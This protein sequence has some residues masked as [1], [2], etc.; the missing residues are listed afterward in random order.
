MMIMWNMTTT[1]WR[2][3]FFPLAGI[4]VVSLSDPCA[5]S[6]GFTWSKR[7][8][9]T[10]VEALKPSWA[11]KPVQDSRS[12]L[13]LLKS[14]FN[15][16]F[17]AEDS[18]PTCP[19]ELGKGSLAFIRVLATNHFLCL[20]IW[21]WGGEVPKSTCVKEAWIFSLHS[22]KGRFLPGGSLW[23]THLHIKV[24]GTQGRWC[25][26]ALGCFCEMAR[27]SLVWA[28][29]PVLA[30]RA[31]AWPSKTSKFSWGHAEAEQGP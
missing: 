9:N 31:G 2:H 5:T 27:K 1:L 20:F 29:C 30:G 24:T 18:C 28:T 23:F 11:W 22:W 15:A 14:G 26:F 12:S 16:V 7:E 25:V 10:P 4:L 8:G 21:R 3:F 13:N 17:V 6:M 19:A